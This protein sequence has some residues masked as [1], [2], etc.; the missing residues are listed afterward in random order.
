MACSHPKD[1]PQSYP[2]ADPWFLRLDLKT[3]RGSAYSE[4]YASALPP[5][6]PSCYDFLDWTD[7][8]EIRY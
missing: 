6:F 4:S 3:A 2:F 5:Q 7:C 1:F 8:L